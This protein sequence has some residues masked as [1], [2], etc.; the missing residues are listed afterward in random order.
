MKL[1]KPSR[2]EIYCFIFS[3]PLITVIMNLVMFEDRLWKDYRIWLLSVP[4]LFI[5]GIC[6]G[7]LHVLYT[8]WVEKKYS[9]LNQSRERILLKVAIL[10]LVMSPGI[11]LIFVTY[12]WLHILGYELQRIHLLKGFLV[13][14]SVNLIFETLY[15]LDYLLNKYKETI[16]EKET[17]EQMSIHH[18]FNSL[19]N[20]VN[21]HFLFNCFNTL[22]SL[23]SEDRQK[24]ELF[25]DELSKVYRYLL[26][27][28]EEGVSTLANELKFIQSYY[29]LL[30]TRH[31]QAVEINVQADKR[32]DPYLLPS[33]TLQLLVENVVKHNMLSKNKPLVID[34]FTTT[35]NK[36]VVNNNLQR[37]AV[38]APSNNVGLQNIKA[39]Y[40]LLK[41]QGFQ[42]MEDEKNFTVV[43][44]LI[45]NNA[46]KIQNK[47][48][49]NKNLY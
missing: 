17:L 47:G 11:P 38:K 48:T 34:I 18:D 21:P 29:R 44:P 20:Q 5:A 49:E 6:Y 22:S 12:D 39:K 45:W 43:L 32:Y 25:L 7:Y 9:S 16:E 27:N 13:G 1:I 40:D 41:Q 4:L 19:K 42:V 28:N 14:V 15:E 46:G 8:K 30:Q 31:G 37:R 24:A 3:M 33:L 26:R 10:F 35:G 23:I 2:L 36:L